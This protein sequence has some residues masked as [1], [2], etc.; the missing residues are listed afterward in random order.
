MS[1][2]SIIEM[3]TSELV[4]YLNNPRKN[5]KAV[6][7]VAE[8]IKEF[9]F[10]VPIIIDKEKVIV[11]G[12]TRLR[13]AKKLGLET[14]PVVIADDLTEDQIKA[15][16]L[17]DNKTAEFSEW[18]HDLL[19]HELLEL[20]TADFE[21]LPFGFDEIE[22]ST[23]ETEL[24]EDDFE[25]ELPEEP[26]AK[27]GNIYK[28][29]RHRLMC[30]DSTDPDDIDKL[31]NGEKA[32]LLF[33]D[34][35]YGISVVGS[36]TCLGKIGGDKPATF[37]GVPDPNH[38]TKVNQYKPVKG[39]ETTETARKSF[40]ILKEKTVN[41]ILWGGNYFT[42]FLTP[43][44]CWL[45]WDKVNGDSNFADCELAWTSFD[46]SVRMY[47]WLWNG[48]SRQGDRKTEGLKRCH[49]TQKPVGVTGK[50][51]GDYS[52]EGDIVVDCFGGSG[53]TLI[54]CEQTGRTCYMIEYE[55][56]YIDI[57]IERWEKLTGEEAELISE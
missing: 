41:Q 31:M 29:G 35:P 10:K 28:L 55:P 33:T 25:A 19:I 14:V 39:D 2:L 45:V 50:I 26:R 43:S 44:R 34:P 42:D 3:K 30:G 4:P 5:D 57:I 47:K 53:T 27:R 54:A 51:L 32:E 15:F 37:G 17:A 21:M 49:P 1:K 46:K 52:K 56:A 20:Q 22:E 16:R 12:H 18:D 6:D 48:M 7:P 13:A 9:G 8:S 23:N 38:I 11:A 36:G 24:E 40:E